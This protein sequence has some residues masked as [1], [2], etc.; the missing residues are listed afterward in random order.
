MYVISKSPLILSKAPTAPF[1][2][3]DG[4]IFYINITLET[5]F[6]KVQM[7]VDYPSLYVCLS[8]KSAYPIDA[9]VMP[10]P[11]S[12]IVLSYFIPTLTVT[13]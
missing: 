2:I 10:R 4:S 3:K 13:I 1:E 6:R 9:S 12:Y 8:G 11:I 7:S 5:E